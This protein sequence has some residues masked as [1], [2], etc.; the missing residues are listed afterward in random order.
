MR[1]SISL[2]QLTEELHD[3]VKGVSG[4]MTVWVELPNELS[5][6]KIKFMEMGNR[7]DECGIVIKTEDIE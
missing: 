4:D 2:K 7:G 3:I 6:K 1:T 5:L